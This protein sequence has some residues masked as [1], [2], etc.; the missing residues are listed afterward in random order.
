MTRLNTCGLT[1]E[2]DVNSGIQSTQAFRGNPGV[3]P[4]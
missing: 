4:S 1:R 2:E 3:G